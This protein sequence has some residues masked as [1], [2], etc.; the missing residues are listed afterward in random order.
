M[1]LV[2]TRR[3]DERLLLGDDIT[4]TIV[5]IQGNAVRIGIEAPRNVPIIREELQGKTPGQPADSRPNPKDN[6]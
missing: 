2:L 1:M 3:I 5:S 6:R 4:I